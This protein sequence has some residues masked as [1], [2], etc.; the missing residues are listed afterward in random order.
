[1]LN[2]FELEPL[3]LQ[4]QEKCEQRRDSIADY[5]TVIDEVL[6]GGIGRI[7]VEVQLLDKFILPFEFEKRNTFQ[8]RTLP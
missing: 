8:P 5:L 6:T 7:A 3:L 4:L 1:M 2:Y